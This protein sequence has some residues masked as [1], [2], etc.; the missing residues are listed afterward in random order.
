MKE[1]IRFGLNS[2]IKNLGFIDD[3]FENLALLYGLSESV[4]YDIIVIVREAAVN[5]IKHAYSDRDGIIDIKVEIMS[6][7][8]KY[9][10]ITVK[11]DGKGF[12]P[13]DIP[14]PLDRNNLL[15]SSGRGLLLIKNLSDDYDICSSKKGGTVIKVRKY[16]TEGVED[17]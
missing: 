4:I 17:A 12:D 10:D 1:T 15:K 6:N 11:D 14:D 16:F 9:M 7:N 13:Q 3:V 8:E 2:R 5:S